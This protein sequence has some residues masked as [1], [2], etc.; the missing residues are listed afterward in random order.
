M[1]ATLLAQEAGLKVRGHPGSALQPGVPSPPSSTSLG[2]PYWAANAA[3]R[4]GVPW[5]ASKDIPS[6]PQPHTGAGH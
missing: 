4:L 5:G 6:P 2:A 3:L 1:N